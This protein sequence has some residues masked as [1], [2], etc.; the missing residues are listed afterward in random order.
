[1]LFHWFAA[2]YL[3]SKGGGEQGGTNSQLII[4]TKKTS[5]EKL[6]ELVELSNFDKYF[7][8]WK[9]RTSTAHIKPQS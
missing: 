8:I 3:F 4:L 7:S 9:R 5:N 6:L 1:M 2:R